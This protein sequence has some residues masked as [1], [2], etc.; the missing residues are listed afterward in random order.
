M[1]YFFISIIIILSISCID[2]KEKNY[3]NSLKIVDSLVIRIPDT[4]KSPKPLEFYSFDN[5]KLIISDY[6]SN[7]AKLNIFDIL[8]YKWSQI[9]IDNAEM[10]LP[11]EYPF[12]YKNDSLYILDHLRNKIYL[13]YENN[14][15]KVNLD[16]SATNKLFLSQNKSPKIGINNN[17]LVGTTSAEVKFENFK[18][19]LDNYKSLSLMNKD[20]CIYF[21]GYND[22]YF[23]NATIV[24]NDIEPIFTINDKHIATIYPKSQKLKIFNYEGVKINEVDVS[25]DMIY[26]YK[27]TGD[28][29]KNAF[30]RYYSGLHNEILYDDINE[31][32]YLISTIF[33]N[34]NDLKKIEADFNPDKAIKNKKI[35]IQTFD[36]DFNA[37]DVSV[38]K[39]IHSAFCFVNNGNLYLRKDEL[40]D[41]ESIKFVKLSF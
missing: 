8:N 1:K 32:Y 4:I 20:E 17:I 7:P 35:I 10:G 34:E 26:S 27:I 40:S 33:F 2:T 37:I 5:N 9:Q 12:N 21:N 29:I 31:I 28:E 24:V 23:K 22:S 41:E 30:F 18:S 39:N 38:F 14:F 25:N 11:N 3:S 16:C 13:K 19:K 15:N 36:S 6:T